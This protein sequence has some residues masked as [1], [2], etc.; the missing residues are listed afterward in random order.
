V[1]GYNTINEPK[2]LYDVGKLVGR[3]PEPD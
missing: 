1:T 2:I 3:Y